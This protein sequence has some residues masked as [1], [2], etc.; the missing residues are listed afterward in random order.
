M[1][2]RSHLPR[3]ERSVQG[4]AGDRAAVPPQETAGNHGLSRQLAFTTVALSGF[5]WR[6]NSSIASFFLRGFQF[7]QSSDPSSRIVGR[8]NDRLRALSVCASSTHA[9]SKPSRDLIDSAHALKDNQSIP[10]RDNAIV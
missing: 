6:K 7:A 2:A 8:N 3:Y 5:F 1:P 9:T 10:R 4:R